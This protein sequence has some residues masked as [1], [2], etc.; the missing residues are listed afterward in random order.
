MRA[1][2][3]KKAGCTALFVL[4]NMASA[5]EDG[6]GRGVA[7]IS[8]LYGDVS[9]RRGDAGELVAAAINAPLVTGD[10]VYTGPNARAEV[11]LDFANMIRLAANSEIRLSEL[12]FERY[13]IQ[14]ARGTVTL[15]ARERHGEVELSLPAVSVRPARRGSYR[16]TVFDDGSAEITVR[17][18]EAEIFTPRGSERLKEGRTMLVRGSVADPEFRIVAAVSEDEWDRWNDRRNRD[19]DRSPAYRY[20]SRDIYG[21]ED[22]DGH[23]RWVWTPEYGWVWAPY[24]APGW[25]PYRFGRWSWIDWWGWTWISYDPWGWAPYHY[26]RWFYA[27]PWGW[28]WFPGPRH[29]RQYWRP[30]LVAFFGI[31]P[32][33]VGVGFN[34]LCWTPLAPFEPYYP[35]FGYGY[36]GPRHLSYIDQSIRIVNNINVT[37]LYRNAQIDNA[38]SGIDFDGFTRGHAQGVVR[39]AGSDLA[40][41]ALMRGPLPIPPSRESLRLTDRET[42]VR[43]APAPERGFYSRR[44]AAMD[45]IPFEEQRRAIE[46]MARR[47]FHLDSGGISAGAATAPQ[48]AQTMRGGEEGRGWRQMRQTPETIQGP[49]DH[50]RR[51]ENGW[52]RIGAGSSRTEQGEAG[53]ALAAPRAWDAGRSADGGRW[54]RLG[55]R[56]RELAPQDAEPPLA[57]GGDDGWIRFGRRSAGAR[58]EDR[59]W[60][61]L[62]RRSPEMGDNPRWRSGRSWDPAA[63]SP[64]SVRDREFPGAEVYRGGWRGDWRDRGEAGRNDF[65]GFSRGGVGVPGSGRISS[66]DP[67]GFGRG[68]GAGFGRPAD[69]GGGFSRGEGAGRMGGQMDGHHAGGGFSRGDGPGVRSGRVQ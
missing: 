14:V 36:S 26:G 38:V 2:W 55:E 23:G 64:R 15:W 25:A 49:V 33:R 62:E 34:R 50:P 29:L 42:A 10:R 11:Q 46:E 16:I 6:P 5:H 21:V 30:A 68:E 13:Q 27:R 1:A 12:E 61:T 53:G 19:L 43:P 60:P 59:S 48:P 9:V 47:S 8:L 54:Q 67:S 66:G 35:W 69:H 22:L 24:V 41:A 31:G 63:D 45:H 40:Q 56:S 51:A 18:G 32:V 3:F 44:A 65:G 20:V 28:C 52:S 39:V 57:R 17:S 37:Q 58:D 7:R 4:A